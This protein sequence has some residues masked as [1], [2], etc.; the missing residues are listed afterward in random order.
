MQSLEIRLKKDIFWVKNPKNRDFDPDVPISAR[1][2]I[3]ILNK[4]GLKPPQKIFGELW[5]GGARGTTL[6][7]VL[8]Q[9]YI[10]ERNIP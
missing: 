5:G 8:Y 7:P 4:Y 1:V 6:A 9:D 10:S 3:K 2:N